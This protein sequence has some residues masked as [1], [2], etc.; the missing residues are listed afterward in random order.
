MICR[1]AAPLCSEGG[2]EAIGE[3]PL[4]FRLLHFEGGALRV[5]I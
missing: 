1:V 3:G 2:I 4:I 5:L